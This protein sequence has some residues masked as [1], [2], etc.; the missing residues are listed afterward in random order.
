[1]Q[2]NTRL[3][4]EHRG[5][6]FTEVEILKQL[7]SKTDSGPAGLMGDTHLKKLQKSVPK[8]DNRS[9]AYAFT[10]EILF[11]SDFGRIS[12]KDKGI[13]LPAIEKLLDR[14]VEEYAGDTDVLGEILIVAECIEY[15]SPRLKEG[16]DVF[17]KAWKALSRD[18]KDFAEN[19]HTLL[20]GGILYTML[21]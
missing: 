6:A 17:N 13:D 18:S 20:V 5:A 9:E 2:E 3:I 8:I 15:S 14:L 1:M 7:A 11:A 16:L 21:E 10:H 4:E 12:L 19:Y